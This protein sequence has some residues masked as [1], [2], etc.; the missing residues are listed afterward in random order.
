MVGF[1]D[2]AEKW[3]VELRG[4]VTAAVSKFVYELVTAGNFLIDQ[5][6]D[7][8][9]AATSVAVKD[10]MRETLEACETDCVVVAS[11]EELGKLLE[12]CP[13]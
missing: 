7:G 5:I 2:D 13:F 3:R 1:E 10:R 9:A 6:A 8:T 11:P 12:R 4:S